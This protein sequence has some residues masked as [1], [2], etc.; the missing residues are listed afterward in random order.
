MIN[1]S[2][3]L[4][5][6]I[7]VSFS[8][9]RR[10]NRGKIKL[11]E[12]RLWYFCSDP[13]VDGKKRI[14]L[15]SQHIISGWKLRE[16]SSP[17]HAVRAWTNGQNKYLVLHLV[18]KIECFVLHTRFIYYKKWKYTSAVRSK[19]SSK[20]IFASCVWYSDRPHYE[21]CVL[22]MEIGRRLPLQLQCSYQGQQGD[23]SQSVRGN[24]KTRFWRGQNV[25]AVEGN[26]SFYQVNPVGWI[27][28]DG[29]GGILRD[30]GAWFWSKASGVGWGGGGRGADGRAF[31]AWQL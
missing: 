24:Y 13:D 25:T 8:R 6:E 15:M 22:I 12:N 16:R 18:K 4:K 29:R 14:Y 21:L 3:C 2:L 30:V 7:V 20:L 19:I 23:F 5:L 26:V 28:G 31:C 10:K 11:L 17:A 9:H 1:T 27:T